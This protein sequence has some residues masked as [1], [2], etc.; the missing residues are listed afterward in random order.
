MSRGRSYR[1]AV[2]CSTAPANWAT[3]NRI[4]CGYIIIILAS[5]KHCSFTPIIFSS[6]SYDHRSTNKHEIVGSV[7]E[8]PGTSTWNTSKIVQRLHHVAHKGFLRD[9]TRSKT[10]LSR[11]DFMRERPSTSN[12]W[13]RRR[14]M[15]VG[16]LFEWSQVTWT[17]KRTVSGRITPK[18]W[19]CLKSNRTVC[20]KYP[21]FLG[22]RKKKHRTETNSQF[23]N[24]CDAW[25]SFS[26]WRHSWRKQYSLKI[27]QQTK[28]ISENY[29][30]DTLTRQIPY[31]PPDL[32][33]FVNGALN[34]LSVLLLKGKTSKMAVLSTILNSI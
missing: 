33:S 20:A 11:Y 9:K 7:G 28:W 1:D 4:S 3:S 14:A 27:L 31:V 13:G 16:W 23:T 29:L 19:A 30:S 21:A 24:F 34:M 26:D 22:P 8:N 10:I 18:I 17:W 2:G 6:F 32:S 25:F 12:G 15:I 5:C